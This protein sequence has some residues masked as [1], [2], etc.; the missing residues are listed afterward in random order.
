MITAGR[1]IINALAA[2]GVDRVY[3]VPGESFL[4]IFDALYGNT[5]DTVVAHHE[6]SAGFMA[7]ADSRITGRVSAA[8]VSRGPGAT[9][10]SIAV[11]S[12]D[13]DGTPFL[14]F[15]G[16]VPRK[17]LRRRSFQEI[18]YGKMFGDI[19]KWVVEI[20]DS[21]RIPEIMARA[22]QIATAP[23]PGPVVIVMPEDMLEDMVPETDIR[24]FQPAA[25][26]VN[27][28]AVADAAAL[29]RTA[30]K[31]LVIAGGELCTEEG[32][33][34]LA[35]C[36][37]AWQLPVAAS[38]RRHDVFDGN[39][40]KFVGDLGIQNTPA[41]IDAV[42]ESDVVFAIGTRLGDLTTQGYTFPESPF[43]QRKL[44][45]VLAD[46]K[47]LGVDFRPDV[48]AG[49]SAAAFLRALA[50]A[51][52]KVAA[53]RDE[54]IARLR[55]ERL[56]TMAWNTQTAPDGVVFGNVVT[57][58]VKRLQPDAV[59]TLDA[60]LSAAMFYKHFPVKAP[61]QLIASITGVMGMGVPGAVSIAM[62]CPGRQVVCAVG[63]GSFLMTGNE[64]ALAVERKLPIRFILAANKSYGSI[65]LNQEKEYPGHV[66]GTDLT[67]PEFAAMAEAF[68]AK[69]FVI[70]SDA[71]IGPM[72]DAAF[73]VDGP[74]LVEVKTSLSS[75]L[76]K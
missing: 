42:R 19:A 58:V 60:G 28:Q 38:F 6:S 33:A 44:I 39:D 66:V 10:A 40:R 45:H 21:A 46:A 14:L 31:P 13:Q 55:G 68:G 1:L 74:S 72:L 70:R 73:A 71:D 53:G 23:T 62:R 63:D 59:M 76:P 57:A 17:N 32:R 26:E 25:S 7:L 29:L 51:A 52:P 41:Q 20:T 36:A 3:C 48:S 18:D 5:I 24:P 35:E 50:K 15:I 61:Q 56:K 30:K 65:R 2:N 67:T 64:I 47:V 54:W 37:E 4:P 27:M 69:G 12:A 9:N 43:P 8:F 75:I 34:A 49:C 22:I 11:H 16:Q